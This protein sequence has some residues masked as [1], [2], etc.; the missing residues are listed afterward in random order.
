MNVIATPFGCTPSRYF[1]PCSVSALSTGAHYK[2]PSIPRASN[3][4]L[5][6]A[7]ASGNDSVVLPSQIHSSE[8]LA[9]QD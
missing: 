1:G 9:L 8:C 3:L 6:L 5:S 7:T 2:N 4:L